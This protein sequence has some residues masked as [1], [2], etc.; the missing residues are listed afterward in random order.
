MQWESIPPINV[1]IN[2]I[3]Y[4]YYYYFQVGIHNDDKTTSPIDSAA[5]QPLIH[6][7]LQ[8]GLSSAPSVRQTRSLAVSVFRDRLLPSRAL[9][10]VGKNLCSLQKSISFYK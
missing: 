6:P 3:I 8:L 1:S 4:V 10:S 2:V 9:D 7:V 5:S